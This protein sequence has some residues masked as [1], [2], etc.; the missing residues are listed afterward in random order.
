MTGLEME[1]ILFWLS[2]K[3]N[4]PLVGPKVLQI[5]LTNR[6]NL[7]CRMCSI[8]NSLPKD[9]ELSTV[10][11][12]H[13]ID[14]AKSYGI[15]EVLLTGGEPFLREDLFEITRYC[16]SKGLRS[17]ITTNGTLINE[18]LADSIAGSGISHLHFSIDG[19]EEVNDYFRGPG[20]FNKIIKAVN[21]LSEKRKKG[22]FFSLGFACTVMDN[23]AGQLSGLV[24]LADDLDIDVINFQPL[25]KDNS[26]FLDKTLPLFWVKKENIPVLSDE[27]MKIRSYRSKHIGVYEEPRL[28][29]LIA[30]YKGQLSRKEWTCFGG[31]KTVFICFSEKQ[32]LIYSCHGICGNLDKVKL[33]SAWLS[34]EAYRLRVHSSRC[35][36][37]C[38]QSCYSRESCGSLSN[39]FKTVKEGNK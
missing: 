27:I 15:Q 38:L 14:E 20:A 5:S 19:L 12:L 4:Y 13:A 24:R 29:L 10:Q 21:L 8:A 35:K 11:V 16:Q 7:S 31:F 37:L 17:I 39:L 3:I 9:Q 22:R 6:C 30:Y 2:R 33:K 1:K 23:N 34:Q 32:P 26:N 18:A 25:V 36:N 28:E